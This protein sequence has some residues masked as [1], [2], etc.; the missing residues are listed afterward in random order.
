V[1]AGGRP[2]ASQALRPRL[3]GFPGLTPS[4]PSL[5]LRSH[6]RLEIQQD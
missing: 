6:H 3:H 5:L 2:P 1:G 4:L